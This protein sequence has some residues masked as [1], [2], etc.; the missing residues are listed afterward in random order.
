MASQESKAAWDKFQTDMKTLAEEMRR[1]YKGADA[2]ETAE[3][4]RSL[5]QLRRGA[6]AVFDSLGTVSRDPAVR[7]RTRSVARSFGTALGETFREVG[8]ELERAFRKPSG[9]T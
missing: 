5:E 7:D 9:P 3:L 1:Q 6:E 8:D 4:N 2:Q